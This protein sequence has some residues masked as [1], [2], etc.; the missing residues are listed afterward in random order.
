MSPAT[1][2]L[3]IIHS[4]KDSAQVAEFLK[5]FKPLLDSGLLA[6]WSADTAHAGVHVE[7]DLLAFL[8]LADCIVIWVTPDLLDGA[9]SYGYLKAAAS[10]I[11]AAALVI[12]MI[13]RYSGWEFDDFLKP[14]YANILPVDKLPMPTE[15]PERRDA[16]LTQAANTVATKLGLLQEIA[17]K[18]SRFW[19]DWRF[20]KWFIPVLLTL[21]G[22]YF[23]YPEFVLSRQE[24]EGEDDPVLPVLTQCNFPAKFDSTHLYILITRFE[25]KSNKD[26]KTACYG[27]N[28]ESRID[29]IKNRNKLPLVICYVDSLSPNQS[30]EAIRLRD[31]YHADLIIWGKL[32]NAD[33]NCQADGFCLKFQPSDT[34]ISYAGG[35]L[36]PKVDNE[37]QPNVSAQDV[38]EGLINMGSE[39]FDAWLLSMSNLKI[40]RK[41]PEFYRISPD[42]PAEKQVD[43]YDKRAKMFFQMSL[44]DK[45]IEDYNLAIRIKPSHILYYRRGIAQAKLGNHEKAIEDFNEAAAL[46]PDDPNIYYNRGKSYRFLNKNDAEIADYNRTLKLDPRYSSVYSIMAVTYMNGKKYQDAINYFS[47]VIMLDPNNINAIEGRGEAK[48]QAGQYEASIEDFN[49]AIRM[50]GN[51]MVAYF[52]RSQAKYILKKYQEAIADLNIVIQFQPQNAEAFNSRGFAKARLERN[53][54]AVADLEKS[55]QLGTKGAFTFNLLG[56]CNLNLELYGQAIE[57]YQKAVQ[58]RSDRA[59][60]HYN[61]GKARLKKGQYNDAIHDFNKAMQIEPKTVEFLIHHGMANNGLGEHEKALEDFEKALRLKPNI[62]IFYDRGISKLNL[63]RYR[64]AIADFDL[65]LKH[66]PQKGDYFQKRGIAKWR[67]GSYFAAIG[68]FSSAIRFNYLPGWRLYWVMAVL[69]ALFIYGRFYKARKADKGK[70]DVPKI[71]TIESFKKQRKK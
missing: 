50:D 69:F 8:P 53:K 65:A 29:V 44:W 25:D 31:I 45:A 9:D 22:L 64:E 20:W 41:K 61:L 15:P 24:M 60:F 49:A 23:A 39:S 52:N 5:R 14:Y 59:D 37:Y 63:K 13:A 43:E 11:N 27:E 19:Q 17:E 10:Q 71:R 62:A 70:K 66:L 56:N 21:V 4:P 28:M 3:C 30:D 32:R 55:V 26:R 40:G 6:V 58:L 42:W 47:K 57:W 34:L 7:T 51:L 12:P 48:L 35:K 54:S 2:R 46:K 38:E 68:D 33:T 36:A 16:W 18:R 67:N 1:K